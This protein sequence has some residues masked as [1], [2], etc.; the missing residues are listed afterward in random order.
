MLLI[1]LHLLLFS[2]T[3]SQ[4]VPVEFYEYKYQKQ[5][6]DSGHNWFSNSIFSSYRFQDLNHKSSVNDSLNIDFRL[7]FYNFN[8]NI[9]LYGYGHFQFKKYFYGFLYPRI[10]NRSKYFD[11]FTGIPR[12]ITRFGFN[13]GETDISGI[14]F[15]NDWITFQINRGRENWGAGS[16][17]QL[18]LSD[19]SPS[20]DYLVLASDYGKVRVKYFHGFLES[21]DN[22]IN[23]YITGRGVE[24]TNK[25]NFLIGLSE[26]VIYSGIDRSIDFSYFNPI[27]THLEIELNNRLNNIGTSN[28]NAVWQFSLDYIFD[29]KIR[30]SF[31]Y[32]YDE[33]VLDD[34]EFESGKEHGKANY[35]DHSDNPQKC[36][37]RLRIVRYSEF[38]RCANGKNH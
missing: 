19:N 9:A 6:I 15:Q 5:I 27:S 28:A 16:D 12:D 17:I 26:V 36:K 13:S 4:E 38:S 18:A 23:R 31:N 29:K 37:E 21:N 11:R 25:A 30:I 22:Q 14:G 10:V 35:F 7:G 32:L 34:S 3:F 2:I 1:F 20:Y 24:F 8:E 33:F